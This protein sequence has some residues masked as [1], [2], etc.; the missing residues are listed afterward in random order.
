MAY[1][2]NVKSSAASI[3]P[4]DVRESRA[5]LYGMLLFAREHDS[6]H[7]A[8]RTESA[9][10]SDIFSGLMMSEDICITPSI[11]DK[12]NGEAIYRYRVSGDDLIHVRNLFSSEIHIDKS[13]ISGAEA[14]FLRGVFLSCGYINSPEQRY[15]LDFTMRSADL[16]AE[17]AVLLM[18]QVGT[19]PKMSVRKADQV[20][21]YRDSTRIVDFLTYIGLQKSAF[22]FMNSQIER[23][24]RNN[25]NRKT[26]FEVANIGK[27][28]SASVTQTEAI[29]TLIS[30][31]RIDKLSPALKVTA[32]LRMENPDSSLEALGQLH[33]PALSKSQV[34]K[35]LKAIVD[36]N[37]EK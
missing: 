21:Y 31:G 28:A 17:L 23:D 1:S 19:M 3:M 2:L 18:I 8:F 32:K 29:E 10:A 24:I 12:K 15:R 36:F 16:A 14:A 11:Y 34:S 7:I 33:T 13:V 30:D 35:R 27:T 26:N 20:V 9:E 6:D 5:E 37:N 25:T 4:K 22:E